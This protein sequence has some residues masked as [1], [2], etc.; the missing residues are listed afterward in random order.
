MLDVG[1]R[2]R[3]LNNVPTQIRISLF[4]LDTVDC[5]GEGEDDVLVCLLL[6]RLGFK[7]VVEGGHVGSGWDGGA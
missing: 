2:C 5:V 7:E 3:L 4:A 6:L 1:F